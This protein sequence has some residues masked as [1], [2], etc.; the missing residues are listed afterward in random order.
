MRNSLHFSTGNDECETPQDLYDEL[1][2]E[3][4]FTRDVCATKENAKHKRF[5]TKEDDCLKKRWSGVCW[6][7]P[8]YSRKTKDKPGLYAFVMKASWEALRGRATVV[9]L[10]AARTDTKWW[11]DFVWWM[12]DPRPGV[13][14]RFIRGRLKFS[15]AKDSAPFPSVVVIFHRR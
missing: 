2:A 13:E 14:V 10:L 1:N 7:N 15:G 5:W 4:R 3:F 6:M 12:G 8:P 11:H 9:C